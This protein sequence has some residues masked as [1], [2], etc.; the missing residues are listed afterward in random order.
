MSINIIT[1][2]L[3]LLTFVLAVCGGLLVELIAELMKR[4]DDDESDDDE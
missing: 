4:S 2:V 3:A 1:F